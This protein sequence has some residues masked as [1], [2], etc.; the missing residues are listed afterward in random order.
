MN[1]EQLRRSIQT[2]GM[3]CFVKYYEAFSDPSKQEEDLIDALMKLEGYEE[4]GAKARVLQSKRIFREDC[5][6][7]ALSIIKKSIKAESW[8]ISKAEFLCRKIT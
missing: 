1:D 8:V 4:S 6:A 3:G 7:E 2:I 5:A